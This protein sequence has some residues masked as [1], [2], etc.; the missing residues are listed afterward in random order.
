MAEASEEVSPA[1]T[2]LSHYHV[3]FWRSCST[4]T[5]FV[6]LL[7]LQLILGVGNFLLFVATA[8]T[9]I[10]VMRLIWRDISKALHITYEFAPTHPR[11]R[12]A[13][14]QLKRARIVVRRQLAGVAV[15]AVASSMLLPLAVKTV[16][17]GRGYVDT[18]DLATSAAI[19]VLDSLTCVA[20]AL[21]LSGGYKRPIRHRQ[22]QSSEQCSCQFA[23]VESLQGAPDLTSQLSATCIGRASTA[24]SMKVADLAGRGVTLKE[25]LSF[26][27]ELKTVMPHF[28]ASIHTTHD[29]VRHAIIPLT[30]HKRPVAMTDV[31]GLTRWHPV[32]AGEGTLSF[33]HPSGAMDRAPP[34][35]RV[36]AL[37]NAYY[38]IEGEKEPVAPATGGSDLDRQHFDAK[39]YFDSMVSSGQL[40][41]LVKRANE[42]DAEIKDLNGDMQMLVYENYSKFIRATDVIK[43]MKFT[44]EGLEPDLKV[45]EGNV[46]RISEHQK[47]VEDGVSGR[48][49]QIE[50]LLKQQRVCRKLQVLFGLPGTLQKCLDRKAYGEAV[51]A[52]CCCSAFLRQHRQMP[53]FQ[54]VLEE[55]ELQMGRIRV[56]LEERL[57]SDLS[58]DEAVNS[59]VTLLDLGEDQVKVVG[60]YLTGR[61]STLRRS[62]A[63][64]FTAGTMEPPPAPEGELTKDQEEL[65]RPESQALCQA[66]TRATEAYVPP[67]C[68][69]VEGYQKLLEVR[70][71]GSSAVDENVLP[72]FVSARI[73]DLCERITQLVEGKCPPSRVLVSCIHSVRDS[74]RRLHSLLPALLTKLFRAFLSRTAMDAMKALFATACSEMLT[75]LCKLHGECKRLGESSS[76]GLDDV[77]EEIARTEQN[78]IKHGFKALTECQPLLSLLG[79]DK[80]RGN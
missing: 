10:V 4:C 53:S 12:R 39:R 5:Y 57:R 41:E 26:Y 55:V 54:K 18:T 3:S 70:G 13:A 22:L 32:L 49:G 76:S 64:C 35:R 73:E 65:R 71:S 33:P 56:A 24:W 44:I 8:V 68:D 38:H 15:N 21:I 62:L 37:L 34:R 20:A 47:K 29:V 19:Q 23:T 6:G 69:A 45:L 2:A 40:P 31:G 79:P 14:Q 60:E 80:A 61:T 48:A 7:V 11:T 43:Q 30:K 52:Y 66:C 74:L 28:K 51:E 67:L 9:V 78:L 72:D 46:A 59:S 16:L 25:L 17:D 58:V 1:A 63:E 42:L 77:L 75:E 36:G 27:S 50:G